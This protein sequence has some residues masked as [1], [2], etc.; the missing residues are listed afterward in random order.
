MLRRLKASLLYQGLP[1]GLRGL[2]ALEGFFCTRS[3]AKLPAIEPAAQDAPVHLFISHG[4][5]GGAGAAVQ[6]AMSH[7]RQRGELAY[8]LTFDVL[9]RRFLVDGQGFYS[10]ATLATYLRKKAVTQVHV[11]HT[12]FFPYAFVKSLPEFARAIGANYQV[13]LH[14]FMSFCPRIHL[15]TDAWKFCGMPAEPAACQTCIESRGMLTSAPFDISAW[16]A[17]WARILS[18]A[19]RVTAP[20]QD[21]ASRHRAYFP[22]VNIEATITPDFLPDIIKPTSIGEV[23]RVVSVGHIYALKGSHVLAACARDAAARGLPMQFSII[24]DSPQRKTLAA[25]GVAVGGAYQPAR[26]PALLAAAA[27]HVVFMPTTV[28]ETY[29]YVLSEIWSLGGYPVAFDFGALAER[30]HATGKGSLLSVELLNDPSAIND[31]LLQIGAQ[32]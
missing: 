23:M 8:E 31:A 18:A 6:A 25:S 1:R 13:V 3:A 22:E 15:M 5:G 7:C 12:R 32:L 19:S 28:P 21:T 2:E 16:R 20:S 26:L 29:S 4:R 11:H 14:D 10:V 27:P 9:K 17:A 24:G 30:I